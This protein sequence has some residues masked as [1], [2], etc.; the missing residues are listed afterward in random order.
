MNTIKQNTKLV[1]RGKQWKRWKPTEFKAVIVEKF[2]DAF[3]VELVHLLTCSACGELIWDPK[4]AN[5]EAFD[6][7]A[8][9]AGEIG[10]IPYR[11]I[12]GPVYA[13]HLECC[14]ERPIGLWKR[15]NT[16]LRNDQREEWEKKA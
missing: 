14:P 6:E 2:E 11:V 10:G 15:L 3:W 7:D 12:P 8:V 4:S 5:I 9:P 1:N 13:F 16:V